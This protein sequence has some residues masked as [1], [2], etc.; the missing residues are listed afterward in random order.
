VEETYTREEVIAAGDAFPERGLLCH[1]CKTRIPQFA[2]LSEIDKQRILELI[3][4]DKPVMAMAA[5]RAATG[6]GIR[7]AK[8][9]VIH[10]G[11]PNS[12][13]DHP[14]CPYCGEPLRTPSAQ[15]CRFCRRDWHN[16]D[17]VE[18][19]KGT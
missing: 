2:D 7:W 14:P 16:P 9:W 18:M 17:Q 5:L 15:Q 4:E 8:I 12:P 6:C 13:I 1:E 3:L 11:Q 19:L 10:K